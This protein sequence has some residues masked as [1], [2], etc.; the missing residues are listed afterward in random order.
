MDQKLIAS[1]VKR[2][3]KISDKE[4]IIAK[5]INA[6]DKI[7]MNYDNSTRMKTHITMA[8]ECLVKLRNLI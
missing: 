6:A 5:L 1:Q 7:D 3:E 2:P 4:D 8:E